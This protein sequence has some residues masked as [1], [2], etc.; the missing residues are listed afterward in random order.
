MMSLTLC[1]IDWDEDDEDEP[2]HSL[3]SEWMK[4]K[5]TLSR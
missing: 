4:S 2:V 5:K 1:L 3:S